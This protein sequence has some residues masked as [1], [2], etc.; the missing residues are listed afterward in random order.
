[1]VPWRLAAWIAVFVVGATV[2]GAAI[3]LLPVAGDPRAAVSL[4]LIAVAVI[5][6]LILGARSRRLS[7]PYW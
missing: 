6:A 4:V 3:R 1:M 5:A 2:G 7:T